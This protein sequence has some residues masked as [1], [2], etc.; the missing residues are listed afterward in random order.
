MR[1]ARITYIGAYHHIISR[2][3]G[4][5]FIFP[6]D[7]SKKKSLEFLD[8]YSN[9][10]GIS[11]YAYTLMDNHYHL[12]LQNTSGKLSS[13]MKDLNG[14]Y[15]SYYRA[16]YGGKGYVFQ[17][18]YWS[19][20]INGSE[21]MKEAIS[22]ILFN[23]ARAGIV[24]D[25]FKYIWNSIY[26][27]AKKPG[28]LRVSEYTNTNVVDEFFD[29]REDFINYVLEY[30]AKK[31][32]VFRTRAGYYIGNLVEVDKVVDLFDRR[33]FRKGENIGKRLKE[34]SIEETIREFCHR[35]SV[36]LNDMEFITKNEKMIRGKLLVY[37]K[38]NG[39]SYKKILQLPYFKGLKHSSLPGLCRHWRKYGRGK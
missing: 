2:G 23:P 20:I 19:A 10:Y 11:I 12:I 3:Y 6:D 22:Y 18:R 5:D 15:G 24:K 8:K 17:G 25:P 32:D 34:T 28:K 1:R 36:N 30:G 16:I 37:L 26:Y 21:Y 13:F 7:S 14:S 31:L 39:F 35:E 9:I 38:D 29:S 33:G 27:D 4:G